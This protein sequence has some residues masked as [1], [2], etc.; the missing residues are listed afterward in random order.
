MI[1]LTNQLYD[2]SR[3]TDIPLDVLNKAKIRLSESVKVRQLGITILEPKK[4]FET[5]LKTVNK[6]KG[7]TSSKRRYALAAYR[8]LV[9][10]YLINEEKK[11]K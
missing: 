4:A 10:I 3:T 5:A 11:I 7:M 8:R 6:T 9:L 2:A 1:E